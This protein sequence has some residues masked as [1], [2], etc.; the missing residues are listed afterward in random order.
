MKLP[1]RALLLPQA[2]RT[3]LGVLFALLWAVPLAACPC[4]GSSGPASSVTARDERFGASLTETARVTHGTFSYDGKYRSLGPGSRETTL[5]VTGLAGYRPTPPLEVSAESAFGHDVVSNPYAPSHRTGLGDTTLRVRF[6]ALEEPM[7]FERPVLPWPAVSGIVSL[8]MPTASGAGSES[9]GTTGAIGSS[10]SSEGLGA[11][12]TAAGVV[13]LGT[14][15]TK[16]Q[17]TGFGEAAYRFP[18][19]SLGLARHL[20][21]RLFGQLGARYAPTPTTALGVLTDLGWEGNVRIR[22]DPGNGTSQRLWTLALFGSFR[23]SPKGLRWGALVRVAPP[24]DGVSRNATGTTS[25]GISL[26]YAR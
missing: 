13:L 12:E 19:T 22:D 5:D 3:A 8:R 18:D 16:W 21:P 9:S 15:A 7:P 25:L 6:D 23:T 1:G 14:I 26:G 17:V 2:A 24:I 10:A 4:Q 11:W 20:P